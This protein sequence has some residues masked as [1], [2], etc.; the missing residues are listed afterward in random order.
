MASAP[1]LNFQ[2]YNPVDTAINAALGV[3]GGLNQ[4]RNTQMQTAKTEAELPYIAPQAELEMEY[5]RALIAAQQAQAA[6]TQYDLDLQKQLAPNQLRAAELETQ[7]FNSMLNGNGQPQQAQPS[8]DLFGNPMQQQVNTNPSANPVMAGGG[9]QG[10]PSDLAQAYFRKK[11]G[12]PAETPEEKLQRDIML[13]EEK[14]NLEKEHG[15][16]A[17]R[18]KIQEEA[19]AIEQLLP[20]IASLAAMDVPLQAGTYSGIASPSVWAPNRQANYEGTVGKALEAQVKAYGLSS[21]ESAQKKALKAIERQ[22]FEDLEN[23]RGRLKELHDELRKKLIA[24]NPEAADRIKP[25][26]LGDG[27]KTSP[28]TVIMTDNKGNYYEI[29]EDQVSAYEKIGGSR[30]E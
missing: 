24:E 1:L 18:T 23:Y 2:A 30:A 29:P 9:T 6:K 27:Q 13:A 26:E 3:Y 7:M 17:E 16:P 12:L 28:G 8:K 15:T 11:A 20:Y 5:R 19:R 14:I 10:T 22:R 21:N 25:L 4:G